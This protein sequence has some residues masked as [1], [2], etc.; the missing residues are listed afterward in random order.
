MDIH[1]WLFVA[2]LADVEEAFDEARR[3]EHVSVFLDVVWTFHH[4]QEEPKDEAGHIV[5]E[6]ASQDYH[7]D[8]VKK[9]KVDAGDFEAAY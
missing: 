3:W 8:C 1:S 6:G 2:A 5:L 7:D 4:S 9:R